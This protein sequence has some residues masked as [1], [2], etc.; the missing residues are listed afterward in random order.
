[1]VVVIIEITTKGFWFAESILKRLFIEA[2]K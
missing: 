2:T 1:M